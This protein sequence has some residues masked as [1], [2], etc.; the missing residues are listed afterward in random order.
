VI[1]ALALV[2][3]DNVASLD[4]PRFQGPAWTILRIPTRALALSQEW[5][6]WSTPLRNRYYVFRACLED[7]T[8]VDLHTGRELDW[9]HPRRASR[10]NHWWK[11]QLSL[12]QPARRELRP[13]YAGYLMRKWNAEHP[14]ERHVASL[15]LVKID[16]SR[17]DEPLSRLPREVLWRG[18]PHPCAC[19]S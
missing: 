14:A 9:D 4:R 3:F 2:V 17:R 16:G 10:N 5:R 8:E 6:L 12:S 11:Y 15:Q 13:A 7:G 1:F 19:E 18:G